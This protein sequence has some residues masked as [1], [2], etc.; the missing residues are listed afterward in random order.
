MGTDALQAVS[1]ELEI[2]N[3]LAKLAHLADE[4]DLDDYIQLFTDDAVW[5]GGAFGTKTGH[6]EILEGAK[7]RR[8]GGTSGPGANTRH[9]LST[10]VIELAGDE[11]R[12]RSVFHFYT[13]IHQTPQLSIMGVYEDLF[14]RT[15]T[16]W[17]LAHRRI[18]RSE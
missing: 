10:I 14:R 15:S 11:A 1:D 5:D 8:A 6:P 7:E 16:G 12:S 2:R 4:G 17:K 13:Q 18:Q 3:Q 9:V